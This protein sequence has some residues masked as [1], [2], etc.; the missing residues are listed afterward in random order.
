MIEFKTLVS[1]DC[2][3]CTRALAENAFGQ[4]HILS[5]RPD[6]NNHGENQQGSDDVP[7]QWTLCILQDNRIMQHLISSESAS[8]FKAVS[9]FLPGPEYASTMLVA[10]G[11]SIWLC[12]E[13]GA[14]VDLLADAT[15]D[16]PVN[17]PVDL[18]YDGHGAV[19]FLNE[20]EDVCK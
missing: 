3:R 8:R 10:E 19:Y 18:R 16:V 7:Y 5:F 9:G 15:L 2:S 20:V 12:Q 17:K 6:E 14:R 1:N 4:L 13:S 11:S